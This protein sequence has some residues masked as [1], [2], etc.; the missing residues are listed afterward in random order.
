MAATIKPLGSSIPLERLQGNHPVQTTG[1]CVHWRT[2]TVAAAPT[3]A[4][5]RKADA[6][7][8]RFC[9][10]S[11]GSP[12]A[13]EGELRPLANDD[14]GAANAGAQRQ[15]RLVQD[16]EQQM[17][18]QVVD[19]GHPGGRHRNAHRLRGIGWCFQGNLMIPTCAKCLRESPEGSLLCLL[20]ADDLIQYQTCCLAVHGPGASPWSLHVA[21]ATRHKTHLGP[22]ADGGV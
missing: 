5:S 20:D 1:G 19:A 16:L 6:G 2:R 9:V 17:L 10:F 15:R 4:G 18:V 11:K 12:G 7:G 14:R 8:H 21:R 22:A 3:S 13:D